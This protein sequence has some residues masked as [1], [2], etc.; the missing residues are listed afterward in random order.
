ML[1]VPAWLVVNCTDE[2]VLCAKAIANGL[3]CDLAANRAPIPF[4]RGHGASPAIIDHS[5]ATI[6]IVLAMHDTQQ[7]CAQRGTACPAQREGII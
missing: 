1:A 7:P 6:F 5:A 2:A 3:L 4:T